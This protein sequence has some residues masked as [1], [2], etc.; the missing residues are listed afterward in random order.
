LSGF[1]VVTNSPM[2]DAMGALATIQRKTINLSPSVSD[3]SKS[4]NKQ[5]LAHEFGHAKDQL[6][7]I[8]ATGSINGTPV[9]TDPRREAHADRIAANTM[10]HL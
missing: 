1:K 5:V 4:S 3:L 10:Q 8:P 7:G 2:P 6:S 9:N